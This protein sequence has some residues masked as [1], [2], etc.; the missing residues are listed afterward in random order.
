MFRRRLV[1][2]A[3]AL[4]VLVIGYFGVTFVQVVWASQ[5]DERTPTQ[6]IVVLG[7]AEYDG[8]PSRVL[9]ARLDHAYDLYRGGVADTV[10][11][12]GGRQAGDRFTE[13]GVGARYLSDRGVPDAA[14]LRETTG[15][16]SWESLAAS[17]RF[18]RDRGI[19]HVTLV[20][21]PFHN[22]RIA[23]IASEL[24]LRPE[25]SPTRTSPITGVD[26]WRRLGTE[27]LRVGIGRVIGY[28]SLT[29]IQHVGRLV[30]GLK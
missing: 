12:T 11:V 9:A 7:A 30:P 6:A 17:A 21:D 29:R 8:R 14:I 24:G 5:R 23:A 1:R 26:R 20:S 3:L 10:V 27:S 2:V 22:A 28:H 25:V 18:L 16:S 13:A 19:D 4:A 15:R